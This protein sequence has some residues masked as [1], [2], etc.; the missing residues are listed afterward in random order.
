MNQIHSNYMTTEKENDITYTVLNCIT[1]IM[2]RYFK[3]CNLW[4]NVWKERRRKR[5]MKSLAFVIQ[6]V[7]LTISSIIFL[8]MVRMVC[9]WW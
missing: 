5:E 1:D 7:I 8:G 9:S 2:R 4:F 6:T 3:L